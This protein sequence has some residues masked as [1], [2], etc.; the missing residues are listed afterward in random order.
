MDIHF[1]FDYGHKARCKY[2]RGHLEL[3][4]YD[5]FDPGWIGLVDDRAHLGAKNALRFGFVEQCG[6]LGHRFHQAH[7]VFLLRKT[8]VHF[9]EWDDS[10]HGPQIVRCGPPLDVP[11]HSVLEQDRAE[12]PVAVEAGAGDHARAHLMHNREH[13]LFDGP[14]SFFDS[15]GS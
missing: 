5:F 3:L 14:R 6:E 9:Q 15:I 11:V 2:L 8:V 4:V 13:L 1:W 12:N 10:F 7:A